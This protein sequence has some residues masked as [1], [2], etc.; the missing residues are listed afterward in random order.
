[1][2]QT[3]KRPTSA[4]S[5]SSNSRSAPTN[6]RARSNSSSGSITS[7]RQTPTT[8]RPSLKSKTN[9][10]INNTNSTKPS[11][12]TSTQNNLLG[13]VDL[14]DEDDLLTK[15]QLKKNPI[16]LNENNHHDEFTS[17]MNKFNSNIQ[18]MI[19]SKWN[20]YKTSFHPDEDDDE[21]EQD[22]EEDLYSTSRQRTS[23]RSSTIHSKISL[24]QPK[25]V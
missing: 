16:Q 23:S 14:D 21:E 2:L 8:S 22:D 5:T 12:P 19:D 9:K 24:V 25:K 11:V 7:G 3:V 17:S 13:K 6:Q 18:T 10:Q 4:S 15:C 1:L 20:A